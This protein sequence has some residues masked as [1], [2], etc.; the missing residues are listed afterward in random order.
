MR[1]YIMIAAIAALATL[2]VVHSATTED[3][4]IGTV[5]CTASCN[6][7]EADNGTGTSLPLNPDD[8]DDD[9]DRSRNQ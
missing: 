3:R 8:Y 9:N 2:V 6:E 4:V 7:A 1:A 5:D